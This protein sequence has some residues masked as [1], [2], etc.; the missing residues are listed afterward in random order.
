MLG[1]KEI[2]DGGNTTPILASCAT[3]GIAARLCHDYNGGSY[4]DWYLPSKDELN[5]LCINRVAIGGFA[6]ANYWSSS[7]NDAYVAWC[8]SFNSGGQGNNGKIDSDYV[9]AVRHF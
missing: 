4:T 2:G 9:R 3:A 6:S 7:E 1:G 8:Q 5:K